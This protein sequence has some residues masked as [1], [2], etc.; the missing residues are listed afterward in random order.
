M[1]IYRDGIVLFCE[2]IEPELAER[3]KTLFTEAE[4]N[5][6]STCATAIIMGFTV[7]VNRPGDILIISRFEGRFVPS[8]AFI[9]EEVEYST[10]EQLAHL[11]TRG[12]ASLEARQMLVRLLKVD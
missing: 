2:G 11:I 12:E 1:A 8:P 9:D 4:S 3:I 7:S 5:F 10:G 6:H